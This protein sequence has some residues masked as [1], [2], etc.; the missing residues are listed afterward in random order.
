MNSMTFPPMD[1]TRA[2][3]NPTDPVHRKIL[4]FLIADEAARAALPENPDEWAIDRLNVNNA[5][6]KASGQRA[7]VA[8]AL[9][10]TL[11]TA[12]TQ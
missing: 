2:S 12:F 10:E 9:A 8:K 4:E 6:C 3:L 5:Y 7:V 11:L 1:Q